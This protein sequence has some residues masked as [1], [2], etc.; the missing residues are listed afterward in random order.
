MEIATAVFTAVVGLIIAISSL[1]HGIAWAVN[2]PAAGF[3]PFYIGCLI[4][5]GSFGNL[6]Q[7]TLARRSL[8]GEF[9]PADRIRDVVAFVASVLAF[10]VMVAFLG[11]YVSTA[12][13]LFCVTIWKAKL[14]PLRAA[15]LGLGAALF[16][17]VCFEYAFKLP[18]PKGP[19]L[20]L[21]GIY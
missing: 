5:L 1:K 8:T 11:L 6:V 13:Y 21:F 17:Y 2:G 4:V 20:G 14:R 16:F 7:V 10:A 3:F 12:V 15:L 19:L 18:L 9:I